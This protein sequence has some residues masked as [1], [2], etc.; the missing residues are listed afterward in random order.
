MATTKIGFNLWHGATRYRII[1]VSSVH[2]PK[3]G[4]DLL[5]VAIGA[6]GARQALAEYGNVREVS[7]Q[8]VDALA[9]LVGPPPPGL[10]V[11]EPWG[12]WQYTALIVGITIL[13]GGV[14]TGI[15]LLSA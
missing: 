13:I 5:D 8:R 3:T 2:T 4:H 15:V 10:H 9:P 7:Q 14:V 12:L 6:S 1:F 11:P